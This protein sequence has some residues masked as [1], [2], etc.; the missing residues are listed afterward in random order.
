MARV[1]RPAVMRAGFT[2]LRLHDLY[3]HLYPDVGP[4][5]ARAL[6]ELIRPSRGKPAE[7]ESKKEEPA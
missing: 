4:D 7:E 6:E 2:P 1:Y 5:T 3:G